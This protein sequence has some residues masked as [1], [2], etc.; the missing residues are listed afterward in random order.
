[1]AEDRIQLKQ[2]IGDLRAGQDYSAG[3]ILMKTVLDVLGRPG[4]P[5]SNGTESVQIAAGF[6]HGFV[7]DIDIECMQ[8][9][10]VEVPEIIG[11]V[12]S[13]FSGVGTVPGLELIFH[14]VEG[15]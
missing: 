5:S 12:M 10:K 11:G 8:D 3:F 6:T 1:M 14:A 7:E 4:I 2:V 13:C 15:L 9:A